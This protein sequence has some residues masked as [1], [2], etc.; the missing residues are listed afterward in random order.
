MKRQAI[1]GSSI[2]LH[3]AASYVLR[4]GSA[5]SSQAGRS[6]SPY[7]S[8]PITSR[9]SRATSRRGPPG[10]GRCPPR[11]G[12]VG[13]ENGHGV[14]VVDAVTLEPDRNAEAIVAGRGP[15]QGANLV[16]VAGI[17]ER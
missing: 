1:R 17:G 8:T 3:G 7:I 14:G 11:S 15:E 12:P 6:I 10:T 16:V 2:E 13:D 5:C 9:L 4:S